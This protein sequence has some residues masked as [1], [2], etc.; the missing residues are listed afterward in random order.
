MRTKHIFYS[1]ALVAAL[2]ACTQEEF[3]TPVD[4]N[5]QNLAVRPLLGDI[6]LT[7]G[8][9]TR[10]ALNE[11]DATKAQPVFAEGDKL[12][13]AIIDQP[14]YSVASGNT[15][16]E[17]LKT[18]VN[19]A[20]DLYTIVENY[21]SNNCFTLN[22][23]IWTVDQPM[24]EGNYLF[25]APYNQKMQART[26]L[27]IV[28]PVKQ[29]AS[30]SRSALEE[31]YNSGS[32]VQLGYQ[33]LEAKNGEPQKPNVA[34]RDVFAY[35]LFTIQNNFSG[36][37][38]DENYRN[39][40]LYAGPITLDSLQV[41]IVN[42]SY[43]AQEM[44][45]GGVLKHAGDNTKTGLTATEGVVGMMNKTGK[46]VGSPMENYTADLLSATTTGCADYNENNSDV[47]N[48]DRTPG[49]IT[50][51][52]FGGKALA[53]KGSYQF[54]GVL[55]AAVYT[56]DDDSQ[57]MRLTLFV[58]INGKN[59]KIEQA[60]VTVDP[61][62]GTV[63]VTG[64]NKA[65]VLMTSDVDK[66]TL[67]KGQK[68]PQEELN[69]DKKEGLDAKPSA[70]SILTL[71]LMGGVTTSNVIAQVGT[72]VP[73]EAPVT[74]IENNEDFIRFFKDQLNGSALA[75]QTAGG[76]KGP[77]YQFSDDTEAL[78]NSELIDALFTYNNKGSLT[79]DRGLVIA[80]DV[81]A[82]M[83]STSGNY[84]AIKFKSAN[85]NEYVIN[86]KTTSGGYD[87]TSN[88]LTSTHNSATLSI[89]VTTGAT[90][91]VNVATTLGNLR[92]DGTLTI[93]ANQTLTPTAMVNNGVIT[94]NGQIATAIENNGIVNVEAGTASV[95]INAGVGQIEVD[96]AN[97][98]AS[99]AVLGGTQTGIYT[100]ADAD[101]FTAANIK[102]A[103]AIAWVNAIKI[104]NDGAAAFTADKLKEVKDINAVYAGSASFVAGTYDMSKVA[105][106]LSGSSK[107]IGG[108]GV[109]TTTVTGI[110][111]LNTT[112]GNVQLNGISAT[113]TFTNAVGVSGK[114]L[115]DGTNAKW[116]GGKAE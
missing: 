17:A 116:N 70:G 90:Y 26:P 50:T 100:L 102:A 53:S 59:Y 52:D 64:E 19:G 113:G 21:S 42:S 51:F 38:V 104:D 103:D 91:A 22:N 65:G 49:V 86:L 108:Q 8:A 75:E 12:G 16:A 84:A 31:F 45:C 30:E 3:N 67:I 7:T 5:N 11:D 66:I 36:Y 9:Q 63:T 1:M 96:A 78:I 73:E 61:M 58:T 88:V 25:Y 2:A 95:A 39:P 40:E 98:A 4:T 101:A 13:A 14:T 76:I 68:Y 18:A 48:V 87:V 43:Q 115:A 83:N 41:S 24:V 107:N 114:I 6:Q 85:G 27:S 94:L 32:V 47:T 89:H 79:I 97:K 20:V 92:N 77:K 72:L 69:F 28:L 74:L 37:L 105:L 44:V 82:T 34:M 62:D 109:G 56:K 55:P 81:K 46:W 99:V 10:F 106:V 110:N 15:Y 33:F 57:S 112:A 93:A 71:N 80:N 54:Y 60:Y 111:I 35:P 23:G 29:D